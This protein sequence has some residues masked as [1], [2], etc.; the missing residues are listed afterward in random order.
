[1]ETLETLG[2]RID[3]TK[4][5]QSIVRTMKALSAVSIRQYER[6]VEAL[7]EHRRAIGLGLQAVLMQEQPPVP[8]VDPAEGAAIAVVFGSDHGLCGHFNREIAALARKELDRRGI[9]AH[10]TVHLVAGARAAAELAASSARIAEAFVLPGS[11]AGLTRTAESL[12]LEIEA[13]RRRQGVARVLVFHNRRTDESSAEPRVTQ[14]LPL[15][16]GWLRRLADSPWPSRARPAYSM[17]A[18][19]VFAALVRQ[20]LFIALFDAAAESAAS[21]HATRLMAMQA[22]ERNIEDRLEDMNTD[23]RRLR[24]ESIT[25]ELLDV[26]A[27]F[28]ALSSQ[29]GDEAQERVRPQDPGS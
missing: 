24:Q 7:R 18:E 20:H 14:L 27:G 26:V 10:E 16:R 11:V 23:Y 1:M 4:D 3:T 9:D 12:L 29:D 28:E 21:E 5:L 13:R 17:A 15:D 2:R 19:A 22:A 8:E 6:A 25:G